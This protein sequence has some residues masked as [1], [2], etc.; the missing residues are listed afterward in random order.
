MVNIV[1]TD[2]WLGEEKARNQTRKE[3][4]KERSEVGLDTQNDLAN[5]ARR[6]FAA[7]ERMARCDLCRPIGLAF[8]ERTDADEAIAR[9]HNVR[10]FAIDEFCR[11]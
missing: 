9:R 1:L 3:R 5:T 7:S 11:R 2:R 10:L 4:P 8:A 6:V